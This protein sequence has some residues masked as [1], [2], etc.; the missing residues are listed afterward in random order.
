LIPSNVECAILALPP[1]PD[2]SSPAAA[3]PFVSSRSTGSDLSQFSA[4][5]GSSSVG[6]ESARTLQL[7][8]VAA[9]AEDTRKF[10]ERTGESLSKPLSAIG[11]IFSEVLDDEPRT[12]GGGYPGPSNQPPYRVRNGHPRTPVEQPGLLPPLQFSGLGL[13][14]SYPTTPNSGVTPPRAGT[15]LDFSAMQAEI[16]RAHAAA[17]D[18][19]RNTLQQ[20]FPTMDRDVTDMVLEANNGDLGLSIDKLLEML[21]EE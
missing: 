17:A 2:P 3:A 14:P 4:A 19:A 6:E 11:R 1:S 7:P 9:I 18:A 12:P 13:S 21:S 16:D 8:Q 5:S 20:I 15:P 10:L